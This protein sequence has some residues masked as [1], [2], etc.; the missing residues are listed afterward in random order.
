VIETLRIRNVA[1][2]EEALLEL[3]P[4]LNVLT[5]E[6]GAG[7]SIVL[8]SL[9]LLIGGR[10]SLESLRSGAESAEVE[11]IFQTARQ[12]AL[13]TTLAEQGVL[14]E[15]SE[16]VVSRALAANGRS[17]AWLSG[18]L[19]PVATLG[20]T[21]GGHVEISS[22]HDSQRLRKPELHGELL[23]RVGGLLAL[24][25]K[26]E[27]GVAELRRID[28]ERERI[29]R[30]S[31]ER[32]Q[33]RDF[34]GFQL[35]ELDAVDLTPEGLAELRSERARLFHAERFREQG[36]AALALLTGDGGE[37]DARGAADLTSEAARRIEALAKLDPARAA[38]AQR[39]HAA[40]AELREA[41]FEVESFCAGIEA[42]PAQL[43][44]LESKL[45]E[46]E[47]R[48]RK[49]GP[50]LSDLLRLRESLRSELAGLE[51][52]GDR[53]DALGAE[54]EALAAEVDAA[55]RKLSRGRSKAAGELARDVEATLRELGMPEARFE[56]AL[57]PADPPN[58][59][60]CGS[61]GRELPEFCFSA[62]AGEEA[63]ALRRVASLMN[64]S[65]DSEE[66]MVLIFDEV[67]AGVGGR[68]A[69]RVGQC[70]AQLASRHQVICITHLPQVAALADVHFRVQKS[71]AKGRTNACV[72]RLDDEARV[73]EIA[74]M[75]G[76]EVIGEATRRHAE[77]LL[78][79]RPRAATSGKRQQASKRATSTASSRR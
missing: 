58:G 24:R 45:H 34:L 56:V 1:V 17:R 23:D 28:A 49:Y 4:G 36:A 44:R 27:R 31:A 62:N 76:G 42:D 11:A 13:E 26:V 54:R 57:T 55:A 20:E 39:L 22:Q 60:P 46:I 47:K 21:L 38:L 29:A 18:R 41:A 3:G 51:G 73:D 74:R 70:L 5:G 6:T 79:A 72:V 68:A 61:T 16:L 43:A 15:G 35:A 8:S 32:E 10:A 37:S 12:P 52:A 75:A 77:E 64:A 40:E 50:E 48:L 71:T 53:A 19:V 33:R 7:K 63:R 14:R 30:A 69:Q 2:V 65:R 9:A 67:D 78:A 25:E 59:L 66:G